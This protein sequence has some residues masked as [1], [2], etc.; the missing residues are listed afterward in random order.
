M[1][2]TKYL[3]LHFK[4]Q[5][6]EC[7]LNAKKAEVNNTDQKSIKENADIQKGNPNQT[8]CWFSKRLIKLISFI[9]QD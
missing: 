4:K 1:S 3:L 9:S 6:K 8:K 7:K 5:E 2:Q